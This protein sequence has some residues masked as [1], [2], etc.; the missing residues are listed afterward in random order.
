MWSNTPAWVTLIITGNA[1]GLLTGLVVL[2]LWV[3]RQ[4]RTHVSDP[5]TRLQAS[6]DGLSTS[7]AALQS[8]VDTAKALAQKA[9]DRIDEI[10]NGVIRN[11]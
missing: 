3:R 2:G 6:V 4:F 7:D 10:L 11:A 8:E 5:I 1:V 9:H